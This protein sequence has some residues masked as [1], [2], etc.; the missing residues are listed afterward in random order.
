MNTSYTYIA[1]LNDALP[2]LTTDTIVS[3]T[4]AH[5]ENSRVVL[6]G[7]APG[8]EL[9]EHTSPMQATLHFLAGEAT[10]TLGDETLEVTAGAWVQ[11]APRLP[12][13][14]RAKDG[15]VVMLLTMNKV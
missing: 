8:Q 11:M 6:F 5:D 4:L 13:S 15:P 7:F 9:S 2:A 10:I 1:N 12:H 3:R 14:I